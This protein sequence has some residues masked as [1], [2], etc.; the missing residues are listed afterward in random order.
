MLYSLKRTE[1]YNSIAKKA[2][3][4]V[5]NAGYEEV[6]ADFTGYETPASLTM[7][8]QNI[9]LTPDFTAKRGDN[10]YYFELVVK[11]VDAQE[12]DMLVSKWKA[13][14]LFAKMKGGSLGLF[15]PRG[16]FKYA[17]SLIKEF[18]IDA[19]IIKLQN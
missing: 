6:K 13:L 9:T 8:Q 10:K 4:Y 14:E 7:V 1:S 19:E 2:V 16:N 12:Q 11:D 5:E 18:G 15:V 3:E 17:T